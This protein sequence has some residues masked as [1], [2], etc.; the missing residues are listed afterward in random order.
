MNMDKADR[1]PTD[2]FNANTH[3]RFDF[4]P[5][6]YIETGDA[7]V[8]LKD[9]ASK[10]PYGVTVKLIKSIKDLIFV[11]LAKLINYCLEHS[12][13]PAVLK[14][15]KV[16]PISKTGSENDLNNFRPI[17]LVPI[18]AKVMEYLLN[19]LIVQHLEK[20]GILSEN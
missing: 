7:I 16:I 15:A 2:Y 6:S 20:H 17:A 4:R 18:F 12:T 1:S 3:A 10:D 13:F 19:K 8:I 5:V 11:P 9:G 14:I